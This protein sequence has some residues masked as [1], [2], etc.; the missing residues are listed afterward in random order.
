MG[1]EVGAEVSIKKILHTT[2]GKKRSGFFDQ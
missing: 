2:T 1:E